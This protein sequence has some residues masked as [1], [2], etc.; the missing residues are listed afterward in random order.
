MNEMLAILAIFILLY[1]MIAGR[2]ER[3]IVS[4][5]IVFVTAGFLF[6]PMGLGWFE[7]AAARSDLR[8]LADFTLALFLFIDASNADLSTLKRNFAIPARLLLLGLPGSIILGF[9]LALV[10]F[11]V[12]T[13]FEAAIL[14]TML[15]A[16]DAALGKPVVTNP[17]VPARMREGLNV[18]SGLNDG[19]C[20]PV[21]LVFIELALDTEFKGGNAAMAI[22]FLVE[23]LG[24]GLVVGLGLTGLASA[25]LH[26]CMKRGWV[27]GTW[28]QVSVI[29]LAL[30]CF[31]V[32]QVFHGSGYIAAFTGGL[33]FGSLARRSTHDM[34]ISAEVVGDMLSLLTWL[35]FGIVVIGQV[36][37]QF[38][39]QIFLYALLSLTAV[40]MVPVFLALTGSG[41][42]IQSKLFIGW[43]GPRG[44][45]SIVFAVIVL[46]EGL[47]GS[48]FIALVVACTVF[49]SLI[50]HGV[51][52]NPL[53]RWVA[54]E[55]QGQSQVPESHSGT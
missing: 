53:A 7:G 52:A 46:D 44:L 38:T 54:E 30:S 35:L 13:V 41:E 1:S 27:T 48:Q 50:V 18:E 29:A 37:G 14:G 22:R 19:L 36:F 32:A 26:I 49:V 24:V 5:P 6:G 8:M 40:R 12:L 42:S 39:W 2:I 47:P 25:L 3:S 21:L 33:L 9:A 11:N 43:F 17:A 34:E 31:E 28:V 45:A 4:G 51:S 20:V 10:M 15:A 55:N 16:T 23:E